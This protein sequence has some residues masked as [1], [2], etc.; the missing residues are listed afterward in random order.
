[1][2]TGAESRS[3]EYV[4]DVLFGLVPE[5]K[6][7]STTATE[8]TASWERSIAVLIGKNRNGS[9]GY[10]KVDLVFSAPC[11]DMTTC[12]RKPSVEKS[13]HKKN[14]PLNRIEAGK[15]YTTVQLARMWDIELTSVPEVV[16][17]AIEN[18]AL[19][20]FGRNDEGQTIYGLPIGP[21]TTEEK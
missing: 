7:T 9:L 12:E 17:M 1:L 2:A 16:K 5:C 19:T 4:S 14:A 6:T 13:K 18:G 8:S 15:G 20:S 21:A 3:I 11:W 10:L